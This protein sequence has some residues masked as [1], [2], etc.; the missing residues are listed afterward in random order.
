VTAGGVGLCMIDL[1]QYA[2]FHLGDGRAANG[3]RVLERTSL[4]QMRAVQAHK[5]GTDDDIGLAWHIRQVGP[6]RTYGHGGTLSGHVLLLELVPERNFAIAI[7]TNSNVGW[8]LIQ[9]VEREA[10]KSYLGATFKPNQA[11]AHRGLV[12]SLPS[13]QPLARQPDL[14]P[15]VGTYMRPSNS[16]VVRAEGG[17]LIV[18]ERPNSGGTPREYPVA[19]Y[20]P[21]RV[22]VTDGADRGQSIEF[23]R[24]D[25]GKVTWVRVVGRV[26]VRAP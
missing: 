15:Y 12:E 1:L 10:L 3:D 17:K 18:Q 6:V 25:A 13:V 8:R 5:Q 14:A 26:A 23:V 19:F 20:G 16:V 2:R 11:I 7:L 9:D 22:V 21:D 4:E 24:D